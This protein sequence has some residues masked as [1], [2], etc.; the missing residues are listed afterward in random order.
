[1]AV[2]S[3]YASEHHLRVGELVSLPTPSGPARLT[4]AAIVTNSGWPAGAITI[5][6]GDYSRFWI[7]P[8][9]RRWR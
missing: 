9:R 6:S 5:S 7:P 3:D 8:K 2:S 4:I 1:M